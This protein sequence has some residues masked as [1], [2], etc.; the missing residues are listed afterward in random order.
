MLRRRRTYKVGASNFY[1]TYTAGVFEA[2]SPEE[3]IE[4]AKES[5]RNSPMG[6]DFK[7]VGAFRFF[8]RRDEEE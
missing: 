6:R 2:D 3:A 1:A 8:I 4:M 7:D 5:Y